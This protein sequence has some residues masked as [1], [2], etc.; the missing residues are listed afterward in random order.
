MR[1]PDC[2]LV[3][4]DLR[5]ICPQC[6]VDLRPFKAERGLQITNPQLS[7]DDL[8]RKHLKRPVAH[9]AVNANESPPAADLFAKLLGTGR[10]SA[11]TT[12]AELQKIKERDE[13]VEERLES[14]IASAEEEIFAQRPSTVTV[15]DS[16]DAPAESIGKGSDPALTDP[17]IPV[18]ST[19]EEALKLN[20]PVPP[21]GSTNNE[22]VAAA[23]LTQTEN[24]R[25]EIPETEPSRPDPTANNVESPS[26]QHPTS[27][28]HDPVARLFDSALREIVMYD[29]DLQFE[30]SAEQLSVAKKPELIELF[31]D[32]SEEEIIDPNALR[33]L[34]TEVETSQKKKLESTSLNVQLMRVE[35]ELERPMPSLA[36][37]KANNE[38]SD[39]ITGDDTGAVVPQVAIVSVP[40]R[41][42]FYGFLIDSTVTISLAA[43]FSWG[44][45]TLFLPPALSDR[46]IIEPHQD[47]LPLFFLQI[48]IPAFLALI[49]LYPLF[50]LLATR[51]TIGSAICRFRLYGADYKA[52]S[53][54]SVLVRTLTF[55]LCTLIG[56]SLPLIFSRPALHE[57]LS[58]TVMA[59][60]A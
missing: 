42:R 47:T 16:N 43:I 38:H 57:W 17:D 33:R 60:R 12:R 31:F 9:P 21:A 54:S 13:Y 39:G 34:S 20:A 7:Y 27:A 14:I 51:R 55:P 48:F 10:D 53:L 56:G 15:A 52:P 26:A 6:L 45:L 22:P 36:Q 32:L 30:L 24:P 44:T 1:C 46:S 35:R 50:S 25:E 11:E 40:P 41:L 58:R 49:V 18:I 23:E 3:C 8:L 37:L 2:N 29:D 5:D 28:A 4:S 59:R 19:P